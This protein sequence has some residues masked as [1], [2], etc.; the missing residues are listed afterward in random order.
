MASRSA[1]R[2]ALRFGAA[3]ALLGGA[4]WS[5]M[6][7]GLAN[8]IER[9]AV[10]AIAAMFWGIA[11]MLVGGFGP[12]RN[13]PLEEEPPPSRNPGV[14]VLLSLGRFAYRSLVGF[15]V[16]MMGCSV[17]LLA[18]LGIGLAF[19]GSL[20]DALKA[21]RRDYAARVVECGMLGAYS[22]GFL[23]AWIG[24]VLGPL[25]FHGK[26]E[27]RTGRTS[28]SGWVLGTVLGFIYGAMCALLIPNPFLA[29]QQALIGGVGAG[30]SGGLLAWLLD[31]WIR[32]KSSPD[33]A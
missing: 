26:R 8:P 33:S 1:F 12:R 21:P 10:A 20:D 19:Y 15:L 18:I 28:I 16:Y 17:L 11:G 22:S 24:A 27:T 2:R 6:T 3:A 30:L 14:R 5:A 25:G 13:Q 31:E 9:L 7:A 23:G 32:L 29:P 4:L